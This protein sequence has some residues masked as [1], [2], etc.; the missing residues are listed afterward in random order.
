MAHETRRVHAMAQGVNV[1]YATAESLDIP[2]YSLSIVNPL[3]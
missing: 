3:E 1:A 2:A